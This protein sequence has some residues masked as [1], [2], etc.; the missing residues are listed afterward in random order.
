V[1]VGVGEQVLRLHQPARAI[2][3]GSP[4]AGALV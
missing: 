4:N 2:Q 3:A 1:L